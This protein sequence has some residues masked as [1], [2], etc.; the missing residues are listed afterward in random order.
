MKT[1][2]IILMNCDDLGWGDLGCTGHP[3]HKTPH[4]DRMAAEGSIFSDFYMASSVCSPSRGAML[5]GCYPRRIGF[6]DFEGRG[7]LFPGW[8]VGLNPDEITLADILK[9]R[10]Y[11][12]RIIGKWHCGDQPPFLPTRHGFDGYYGI[13]YSNDMG[14]QVNEGWGRNLPPLPLLRDEEVIEAQFDQATVTAR[15]VEDAL[16]FVRSNRDKPFFLYLAHMYV[17]LPLYVQDRFLKESENDRYGAAVAAID[18]SMGVL[19]SELTRLEIDENT[20]VMFTSDN[21][22]RNDFGRSCGPLRGRKFTTWEG[23]LRVPFVARWPGTVPAGRKIDGILS[24][25]DLLPTL[26]A[27]TGAAV[28]VDRT[29]DGIDV[30]SL[31]LGDTDVSPRTDFLFYQGNILEAVRS[32]DWKLHIRKEN[33]DVLELYNLR[34]DIAES[35]NRA[36]TEPDILSSLKELVETAR[37]DLGDATTGQEGNCRPIGR[38]SEGQPLTHYD[39]AHPYYMAEYDLTEFG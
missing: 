16:S 9:G 35:T 33:E 26:A 31:L 12:T 28:P 30:S 11:S 10:G 5:T 4:L 15:Y 19:L 37:A 14:R 27:V 20:L 17:H 2:N 18:W 32:G 6:G 24:A 36:A 1:P 3:Q 25:I 38:V 29:I 23:G 22:S 34:E 21:G 39:P 8:P 13:P 7:V